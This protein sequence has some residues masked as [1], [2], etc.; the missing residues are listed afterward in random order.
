MAPNERSQT[1][2][3]RERDLVAQLRTGDRSC[4]GELIDMHGDDLFHYLIALLGDRSVAEDVFQDVWIRVIER[5]HRFRAG[6]PLAPWLFRVARNRAFDVL[7][8]ER[9]RSP[10]LPAAAQAAPTAALA[11]E[12]RIDTRIVAD[13]LAAKMLAAL[14]AKHREVL[15]LRFYAEMSYEEIAAA[16]RVPLGTVKSR[17]RRAL[18]NGAEICRR[19]EESHAPS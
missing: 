14:P 7:R 3:R 1:I 19:L 13:D 8:R 4:L 9:L 6:R 17:L 15:W 5:I 11:S 10:R 12:D 18:T 16:C 2:A